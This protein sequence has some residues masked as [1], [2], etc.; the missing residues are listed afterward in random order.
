MNRLKLHP[1][2]IQLTPEL[3]IAYHQ[4]RLDLAR[5]LLKF[6][7]DDFISRQIMSDEAY[8]YITRNV[9]IVGIG[10]LAIQNIIQEIRNKTPDIFRKVME[11]VVQ[12]MRLCLKNDSAMDI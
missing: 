5:D 10:V 4:K 11:T 6:T 1:Y 3:Q 2:K 9:R 12:R 7:S 8:F